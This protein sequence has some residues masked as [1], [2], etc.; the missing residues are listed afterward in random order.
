MSD[1]SREDAMMALVP[2]EWDARPLNAALEIKSALKSI[3]DS[4]TSIDSGGCD[5]AADLWAKIDGVEYLITI[6]PSGGQRRK[7]SN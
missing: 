1:S 3:I 6:K 5:G 7:E 2:S 4:G